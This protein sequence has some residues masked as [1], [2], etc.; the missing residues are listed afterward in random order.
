VDYCEKRHVNVEVVLNISLAHFLQMSRIFKALSYG[1]NTYDSSRGV[2]S[3]H[4]EANAIMNLPPR[5]IKKHLK[6][7]DILVIRTSGT[8]KLGISKPCAKCLIDLSN[9]P[10]KR[11]YIVKNI[12]YTSHDGNIINTTLKKLISSDE[13]HISRFYKNHNFKPNMCNLS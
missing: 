7:I 10:Q 6:K 12:A 1:T 11:G 9:L 5:P 3:I 8:A 4:A 13:H 2:N